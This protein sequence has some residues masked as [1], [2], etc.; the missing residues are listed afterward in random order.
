MGK[1]IHILLIDDHP[2]YREGIKSILHQE[3]DLVVVAEAGTA[4]EGLRLAREASPH[5]VLLDIS[6]PDKDGFTLLA[7]I[8]KNCPRLPV[9]IVSMHHRSDHIIRAFQ[10][11]A[12]GFLSKESTPETLI[13]GIRRVMAGECHLAPS[14]AQSVLSSLLAGERNHQQMDSKYGAITPREQE[15]MRL[16]AEGRSSREIADQFF[17][18]PKTV[19][20][21]RAN[22]MRKLGLANTVDIVRSAAR[23]GLIDLD[24]WKT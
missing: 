17:I 23:L 21:H 22:I 20:N 7:E 1:A 5:I 11:G 2:L 3:P 15:I 12:T 18:S 13:L 16:I 9:L 14:I 24:N 10:A 19:D 4:V 6:L 8:R